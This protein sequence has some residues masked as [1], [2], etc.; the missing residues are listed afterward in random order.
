MSIPVTSST[1]S[2]YAAQLKSTAQQASWFG[3]QPFSLE[4][5][6]TSTGYKL[7][8]KATP[9]TINI[10]EKYKWTYSKFIEEVPR[11]VFIEKQITNNQQVEF[12]RKRIKGIVD[13]M[14]GT[15]EDPYA[16]L[17]NAA[18]TNFQYVFPYISGTT[19][20]TSS[21]WSENVPGSANLYSGVANSVLGVLGFNT[22]IKEIGDMVTAGQSVMK[23]DPYTGIEQPMF[24]GG[25]ER[26][27]F[28]IRFPLFNTGTIQEV[29]DNYNFIRIFAFQNL[30]DR[31]SL[32]TYDPPVIYEVRP[33]QGHIG[34]LGSRPAVYVSNFEV[35]NIGA[36][37]SI[38]IGI[39]NSSTK[40]LIPEAY[41]IEITCSDLIASSRQIFS[42]FFTGT[43]VVST[44]PSNTDSS[45][46][47]VYV[48][49]VK[50][51]TAITTQTGAATNALNNSKSFSIFNP[52]INN[53]GAPGSNIY[54]AN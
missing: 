29:Q 53:A 38:D 44:D 36:V 27:T 33:A 35:K 32:V 7:K 15:G 24:F 39:Q 12:Y 37:R 31:K 25:P 13:N 1:S 23:N 5:N 52:I 4:V 6:E 14:S 2:N 49:S 43:G 11:V 42:S 40:V 54:I 22:S 18:L 30:I 41:M 47:N 19:L 50:G 46:S 16:S 45:P 8:A 9:Q 34:A 10:V 20:T 51:P 28:K 26:Q 3:N 48:P 17:Y 21:R